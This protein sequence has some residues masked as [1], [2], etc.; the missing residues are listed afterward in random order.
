[1][2]NADVHIDAVQ[3]E[4]INIFTYSEALTEVVIS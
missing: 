3:Y 4:L 2:N 1:M